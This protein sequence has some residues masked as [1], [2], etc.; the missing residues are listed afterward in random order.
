MKTANQSQPRSSF[1]AGALAACALIAGLAGGCKQS[2]LCE[3]LGD[4]GGNAPIGDWLLSPGHPS[5]SEDLYIP[6][7]DTR[8]VMGDQVVARTPTPEPA[9]F[10]WCLLLVTHA[11]NI[12]TKPPR[13][14]Y[15]SGPIGAA[16]VHYGADGRYS[17]GLTRTG[18][19]TLDFPTMCMRAFGAKD[20]TDA[21]GAVIPVCKQ[22]E[23]PL[24]ASGIGEGSYPNTTCIPN[25]DD[26]GGC[27]CAFDVTET[28]GSAGTYQVLE[29]GKTIMHLPGNNFP[30]KATFCNKGGS[31]ELT[32]ADGDYLFGQRGLRTLDLAPFVANCTDGVQGAG[33]DGVDCGGACPTACAPA[34]Q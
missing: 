2:V 4:C 33:E 12:L 21:T 29:D 8:L 10:D 34:A 22:L 30:M 15:E 6:P 20:I 13:F 17:A 11:D 1:Q 31:L 19:Y 24:R 18:T 27:L 3:E 16:T 9:L 32:G 7:T 25:K 5:C 28:G 23:E 26:P 14:Y